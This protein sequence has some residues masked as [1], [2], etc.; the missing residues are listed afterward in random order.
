MRFIHVEA[1]KQKAVWHEEYTLLCYH[2]INYKQT[3]TSRFG[4]YD[5]DFLRMNIIVLQDISI[6]MMMESM[7]KHT[8]KATSS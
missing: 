4:I 2:T 1:L 7:T 8:K 6:R 5:F 3:G